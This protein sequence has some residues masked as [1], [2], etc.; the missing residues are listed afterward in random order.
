MIT[1]LGFFVD[2]DGQEG[3]PRETRIWRTVTFQTGAK[4]RKAFQI[5]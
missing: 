5:C 2:C 1:A 4:E 3:L